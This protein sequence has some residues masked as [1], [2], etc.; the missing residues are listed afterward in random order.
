MTPQWKQLLDHLQAV[1]EQ[2]YEGHNSIDGWDNDTAFGRQFGENGVPWCVIFDW[3]VYSDVGLAAIVPK[4]DN[5]VVFSNWARTHGQWSDYPSVGAWVNFANGHTELV[6]GFD[7]DT[8]FT[9]GGNSVRAGAADAGQGNGVWSH[10]TPRRSTRVVGYFAPHFPD[11]ICPPT[12]D[13]NDPRGGRAQTSY[14][15]P[16]PDAAPTT[17]APAN[18]VQ[19]DDVIT[20]ADLQAIGSA[21]ANSQYPRYDDKGAHVSDAPLY[22]LVGGFDLAV[23]RHDRALTTIQARQAAQDAALAT[24]LDG[25]H[26]LDGAAVIA[27]ISAAVDAAVHESLASGVTLQVAVTGTTPTT[28]G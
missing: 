6:T 1:P 18:P 20:P 11:G 7:A 9:K 2:V 21:V 19:E 15:W 10:A 28:K 5:V 4:V 12:A 13:P 25:V 16:G 26:G 8:V 17:P 22:L 24:L 14:T 27:R 23:Q 3:D